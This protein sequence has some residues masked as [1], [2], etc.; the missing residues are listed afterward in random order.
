MRT[1]EEVIG[2]LRMYEGVR[3]T[4]ADAEAFHK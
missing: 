2:R 1:F 3:Q 4:P